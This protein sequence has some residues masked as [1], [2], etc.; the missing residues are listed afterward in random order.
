MILFGPSNETGDF[1]VDCLEYWWQ[2]T[3]GQCSRVKR[4]VIRLDN[5][6]ICAS[7]RRL[8]LT[9]YPERNSLN[10]ATFL[11]LLGYLN[12]GSGLAG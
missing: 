5:G 3:K 6:P 7:D 8:F 4:L 10:Y 12:F 1:W 9:G 2:K 11:A